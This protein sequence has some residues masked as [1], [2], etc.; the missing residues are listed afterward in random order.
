[1]VWG[2]LAAADPEAVGPYRLVRR[3]GAGGMGPL[4]AGGGESTPT[5]HDR[6]KRVV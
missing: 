1:M 3:L 5:F 2:E 4:R 6:V